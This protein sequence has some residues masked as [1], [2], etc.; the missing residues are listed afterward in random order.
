[1]NR[2]KYRL[3]LVLAAGVIAGVLPFA[4]HETHPRE[5]T[6]ATKRDK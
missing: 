1:M 3:L 6:Q 5:Q 2:V 4:C